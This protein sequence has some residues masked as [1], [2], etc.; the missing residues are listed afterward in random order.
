[1]NERARLP[2]IRVYEIVVGIDYSAVS[3]RALHAAL[4][5]AKK[6]T[7]SRVHFLA[8]ASGNGAL[9]MTELTEVAREVVMQSAHEALD[10]YVEEQLTGRD[11]IVNKKSI[12]TAVDFGDP[13][14]RILALAQNVNANLIVLGTHSKTNTEKNAVGSVTQQVLRESP[15]SVLV[16]RADDEH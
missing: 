15:C 3:A 8:I 6:R 2:T 14:E 11:G 7:G 16:V 13:A 10:S 9:A 1:M 5:L 12:R 4:D